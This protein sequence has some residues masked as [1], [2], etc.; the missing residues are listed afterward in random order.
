MQSKI[1]EALSLKTHP[2]ALTWADEAPV[3]ALRFKPGS[4]GCVV[5]LIA[6]VVAKG[7]TA[8]FDRSSYGCWGGGVGLGF[9]NQYAVFPGGIECFHRF[10]ADGN[11]CDPT[12]KAIGENISTQD[13]RFGGDFLLGERYLKNADVTKRFVAGLPFRDVGEKVVIAKPLE[14]ISDDDNVKSVT[15]FVEPDGIA[16]LVNLAN[17]LRPERENVG[18]PWAAGCQVIGI[19]AYRELRSDNPRALVGMTDLSA[20]KN[21]RG[22][23]GTQV[24]S[25]TIPWP[26]FLEMEENVEGSFFQRHTWKALTNA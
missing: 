26:M 18:I 24:M 14:S 16:A 7:K 12:G 10:L 9:G 17:H 21:V 8:A 22:Q 5:S 20:R 2:V 23:L 25:F 13:A 6:S 1:A 19:F 11:Q 3:G 15:F 4:W